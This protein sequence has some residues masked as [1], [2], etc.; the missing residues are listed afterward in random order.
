MKHRKSIAI[1]GGVLALA[2][3]FSGAAQ[4]QCAW[5]GYSW[6]CGYGQPYGGSSSYYGAGSGYGY[7]PRGL[8]HANGPEPGGS[9]Y[10]LGQS[11]VGHS[12]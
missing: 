12:D 3:G 11:N 2:L 6:S 5:N 8:P 7:Q 4:A 9:Y 1:A 10:H